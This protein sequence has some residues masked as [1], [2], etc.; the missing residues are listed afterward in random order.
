MDLFRKDMEKHCAYC[1]FGSVINE[2]E[3]ACERKGVMDA[4]AH[5]RKFR[6]DPLKRVPPRPASLGGKKYSAEDFTL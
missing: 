4:A 2:R 5:C 1:A 3:V 6:Y